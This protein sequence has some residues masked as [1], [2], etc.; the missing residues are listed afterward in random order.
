[1]HFFQPGT[2]QHDNLL[3]WN[4]V[5]NDMSQA[6]YDEYWTKLMTN[7]ESQADPELSKQTNNDN[8]LIA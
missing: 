8:E 4:E 7:I 2:E 5:L 1:M 3:K 6:E